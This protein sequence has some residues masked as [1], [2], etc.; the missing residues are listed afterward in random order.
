MNAGP[1]SS[2][3]EN[4]SIQ[5]GISSDTRLAASRGFK[6][7]GKAGNSLGFSGQVADGAW[8]DAL[9]KQECTQLSATPCSTIYFIVGQARVLTAL[10]DVVHHT[11]EFLIVPGQARVLAALCDAV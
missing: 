8:H 7:S 5:L 6:C 10:C 9:A 2:G 3:A 1:N 4:G 11:S